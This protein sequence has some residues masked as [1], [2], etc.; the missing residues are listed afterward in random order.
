MQ[1]R[2]TIQ[3]ATYVP[4]ASRCSHYHYWALVTLYFISIHL[5]I[6]WQYIQLLSGGNR[7][8][9][10]F[11]TLHI[12]FTNLCDNAS[13]DFLA[14]V[15]AGY[16]SFTWLRHTPVFSA[17][18]FQAQLAFS[19]QENESLHFLSWTEQKQP[20]CVQQRRPQ[21]QHGLQHQS[22]VLAKHTWKYALNSDR[23]R[24]RELVLTSPRGSL[25]FPQPQ[26]S[27]ENCRE[28]KKL[29]F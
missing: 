2:W 8:I 10:L 1:K 14:P 9:H 23:L 22:V 21:E 5:H 16:K 13:I 6:G 3:E 18:Q 11:W 24:V 25:F 27:L 28:L 20:L 29:T 19:K 7:I 17:D 4:D 12:Y 26:V 15:P